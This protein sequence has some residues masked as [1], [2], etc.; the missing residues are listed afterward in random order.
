MTFRDVIS[1]SLKDKRDMTDSTLKTYTSL[2]FNL[3]QK[4]D[5]SINNIG[6]FTKNSKEIITH[7]NGL[8][9][10]QTRKTILSALFVL[11]GEIDYKTD[12]LNNCQI[13]NEI[14]KTGKLSDQ[15][16]NNR[17]TFEQ[18]KDKTAQFL[19][20]LKKEPSK[21][22]YIDYLIL[23]LMSGSTDGIVPRRL[24]WCDVKVK[25]YNTKTDNYYDKGIVYF[26]KY[27]TFK[28]YGLQ[29]VTIPLVLKTLITKWLKL[30]DTDYLIYNIKT[31]NEF[32][33]STL[34]KRLTKIFNG[35]KI[36]CDTLRSIFITDKFS[37][38]L[39]SMKV[40]EENATEMG[41]TVTTQ[42]LCYNKH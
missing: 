21:E 24:E 1:K 23:A 11:T 7:I 26:N 9:S 15:Q 4:M 22:N 12:M 2:L 19:I 39:P 28:V 31:N 35:L 36:G 8:K 3:V 29:K 5:S 14:Y 37:H 38:A 32:S 33:P 40:L 20:N 6:F 30:N 13:V 25:N 17:L 16:R 42:L 18:I 34:N 27:K 10:P 41:N